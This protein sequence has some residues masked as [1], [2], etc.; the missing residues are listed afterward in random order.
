MGLNR[1]SLQVVRTV[2]VNGGKIELRCYPSQCDE[3]ADRIPLLLTHLASPADLQLEQMTLKRFARD[4]LC[5]LDQLKFP[6]PMYSDIHG[7]A[8]S[9]TQF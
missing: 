6:L 9:M 1:H 2:T 8:P 7:V 4:P 3:A 5:S